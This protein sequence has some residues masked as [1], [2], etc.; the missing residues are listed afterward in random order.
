MSLYF[1][2]DGHIYKSIEEDGIEWKGVTSFI[3]MFKPK[4]DQKG[5]A[6][7][8][9]KN[10]RSKWYGKTCLL[11][12]SDAADDASSVYISVVAVSLKKN[13]LKQ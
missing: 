3:G 2:E 9:S 11:Y 6:L 10:K 13:F 8:C 12:T 7:K 1:Q 5:V 4:F